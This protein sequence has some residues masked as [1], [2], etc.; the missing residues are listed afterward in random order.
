M[1][2][3][4]NKFFKNLLE[5]ILRII[6]VIITTFVLF[7]MVFQISN[8]LNISKYNP[9]ILNASIAMLLVIVTILYAYATWEI[10]DESKK[11]RKITTQVLNETKKDRKVVFIEKTLEELYYPLYEILSGSHSN[12]EYNKIIRYSYLSTINLEESL[13]RHIKHVKGI[14][15]L[16]PEDTEELNNEIKFIIEKDIENFKKELDDLLKS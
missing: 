15:R 8:I 4:S 3:R 5:Q 12:A 9:E 1:K 2:E 13:K 10:V 16:L 6:L 11:T 14:E 7:F